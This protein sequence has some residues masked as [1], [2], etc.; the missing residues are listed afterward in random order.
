MFT[1]AFWTAAFERA[2]KTAAQTLIL[3]W[4][5]A[6]GVLN[7][8]DIDWQTSG[9]LA[10]GGF[11]LSILTSLASSKVGVDKT[12]PNVTFTASNPPS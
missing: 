7:L 4:P 10:A 5:V 8:W 11:V 3:V 1:R 12:S 6:D 9:G 2:V